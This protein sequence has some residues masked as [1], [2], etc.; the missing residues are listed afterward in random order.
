MLRLC[1]FQLYWEVYTFLS[2]VL[3]F[4][5]CEWGNTRTGRLGKLPPPPPLTPNSGQIRG[6]Q[7][8]LHTLVP[9]QDSFLRALS[10]NLSPALWPNDFSYCVTSWYQSFS[11]FPLC[12]VWLTSPLN[13]G[14]DCSS[15]P[16]VVFFFSFCPSQSCGSNLIVNPWRSG[17]TFPVGAFCVATQLSLP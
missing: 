8:L 3:L 9:Q 6:S 4:P 12:P 13:L 16:C 11:S 2:F 5:Y 15:L 14:C 17:A 10:S 7:G 1:V